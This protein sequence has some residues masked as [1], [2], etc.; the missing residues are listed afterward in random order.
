MIPSALHENHE[1]DILNKTS[2]ATALI[3]WVEPDLGRQV[4]TRV[5]PQVTLWYMNLEQLQQK[6]LYHRSSS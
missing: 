2:C 5:V 6:N 4:L 3:T 1:S